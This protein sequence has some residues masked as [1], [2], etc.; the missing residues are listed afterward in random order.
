MKRHQSLLS[1][2]REHHPALLLAQ[3]LK[4]NAPAYKGMPIKIP[5]KVE[6]LKAKFHSELKP[7]FHLEEKVLFP[8]LSGKN[9]MID[10]LITDLKA[11]HQA[12]ADNVT[13]LD[14]HHASE[15]LLDETG[16]LLE[17]HIRKEERIL[18]QKIQEVFS[19]EELKQ[20]EMLLQ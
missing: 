4:R 8:F 7:H 11:D 3:V 12:F 14:T 1:L 6:F 13:R 18:F 20:L 15:Q 2:S 9:K 19:E 10:E 16:C 5:D 17:R